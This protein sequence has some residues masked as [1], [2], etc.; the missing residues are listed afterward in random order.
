[1]VLFELLPGNL[2]DAFLD[3]DTHRGGDTHLYAQMAAV[4]SSF[5]CPQPGCPGLIAQW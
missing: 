4:A 2:I 1:M 5:L 3:V